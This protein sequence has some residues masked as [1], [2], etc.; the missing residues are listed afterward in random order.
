MHRPTRRQK[1]YKRP[2]SSLYFSTDIS[3]SSRAVKLT[4]SNADLLEARAEDANDVRHRRAS[5]LDAIRGATLLALVV[6]TI[7]LYFTLWELERSS[8]AL[9]PSRGLLAVPSNDTVSR[10]V[11][12]ESE[13][14][15][16]AVATSPQVSNIERWSTTLNRDGMPSKNPDRLTR[17]AW[18]PLITRVPDEHHENSN[19]IDN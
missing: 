4:T 8:F 12:L 5:S 15:T 2:P 7:I 1:R 3:S 6:V 17:N 16:S 14:P 19:E 10:F 18:P 9:L 13:T 11:S